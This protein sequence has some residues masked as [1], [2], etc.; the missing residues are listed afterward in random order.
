MLLNEKKKKKNTKNYASQTGQSPRSMG[1]EK[2]D[3]KLKNKAF[4]S[5]FVGKEIPLERYTLMYNTN[6][7]H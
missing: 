6:N 2:G 7:Y 4:L 3:K 5:R 1:A